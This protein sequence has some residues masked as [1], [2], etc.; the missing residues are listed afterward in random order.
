MAAIWRCVL[1]V[2]ASL[3]IA[4][5]PVR[6]QTPVDTALV[7]AVDASGS[8]DES[9][10][11]LQ[12]E[13]IALAVTDREV[14]RAVRSGMLQRIAVAY[15]EWGGP[16][17][18]E[19]VV[20]WALVSDEASAAGFA[21]AVL[22]APR[23]LQSYNAIG[24]AIDHAAKLLGECPCEPTRRVIDISGDNPDMRSVRPAPRARDAA[25]AGG[26][27]INALAVLE[28]AYLGPSGRP[29]LVE[30]FEGSVIGGPGAF[31]VAAESRT[32]F[33]RAMRRKMILEIAGPDVPAGR[34][35]AER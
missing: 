29:R 12:K 28:N 1:L 2:L 15:V 5:H 9:E 26:I 23:S 7:L 19:T 3:A 30:Y 13:G 31:V 10:F 11:R 14:L 34:D 20:G 21:D 35:L 17:S 22:K 18:A 8:I 16:L 27:V 24:D 6:A 25:V 32:D 4:G 33:A